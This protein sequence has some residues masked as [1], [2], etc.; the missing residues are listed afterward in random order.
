MLGIKDASVKIARD[1]VPSLSGKKVVIVGGT[2]GIGAALSKAASAAGADV[3]VVGRTM[4]DPNMKFVK[5]DLS[6]LSTAIKVAKELPAETID[7]LIFTN[8]I[9]PGKKKVV[10]A[11]GV[12][13]DVAVSALNRHVMLK[14]MVPRLQPTARVL[15]WGFPGGNAGGKS[16][17]S[18][19]NSEKKWEGEL[20]MAHMN[21]V[22]L[23]EALTLHYAAKGVTTAGFNPG[24]IYTDIRKEMTGGNG[25]C[26]ECCVGCLLGGKTL[27]W[28]VP[29]V[30][31]TL[32]TPELEKHRGQMFH[33]DGSPIK[34]SSTLTPEVVAKW[35]E[36]ADA[37]A[38]KAAEKAAETSGASK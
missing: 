15:I 33:Q 5:A 24:I 35:I 20:G 28:Y 2:A 34:P 6:L 26:M 30:L 4:R 8:G 18:D 17:I 22:M 23:N 21:T 25:T 29:K 10:T 7:V 32:T 12:E 38:A 1:G 36:A 13:L 19:L 14:E 37:L 11:E 16:D 27:E 31:Y 9:V 3:T